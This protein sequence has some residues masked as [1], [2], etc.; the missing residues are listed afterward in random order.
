MLGDTGVD[1]NPM[2]GANIVLPSDS[3]LNRSLEF[4]DIVDLFSLGVD[5]DFPRL[6]ASKVRIRAKGPRMPAT[7]TD[8]RRKS[9]HVV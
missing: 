3:P 6:I 4:G 1:S 8:Q 2:F 9:I 7:G 5:D